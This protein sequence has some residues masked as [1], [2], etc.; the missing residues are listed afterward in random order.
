MLY[1][2]DE[3][4]DGLISVDEMQTLLRNLYSHQPIDREEVI[5]IMERDLDMA[6]NT[7]T[8]PMDK[9]RQLL[10]EIHH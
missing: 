10:L 3:N 6:P 9:V 4:K 5:F 8:V 7:D 2:A 1:A